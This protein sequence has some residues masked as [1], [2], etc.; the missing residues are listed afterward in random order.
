MVPRAADSETCEGGRARGPGARRFV[1]AS[2]Q[3]LF[4]E[5]RRIQP[6]GAQVD[7]SWGIR[8]GPSWGWRWG[9]EGSIGAARFGS[10]GRSRGGERVGLK[11]LGQALRYFSSSSVWAS[12]KIRALRLCGLCVI[13]EQHGPHS[14]TD[15]G[16]M[17]G[18]DAGGATHLKKADSRSRRSHASPFRGCSSNAHHSSGCTL[19]QAV[20]RLCV[21]ARQLMALALWLCFSSSSMSSALSASVNE[22]K[23]E[24]LRHRLWR[25]PLVFSGNRHKRRQAA[26]MAPSCPSG[27]NRRRVVAPI[28]TGRWRQSTLGGGA[29]RHWAVAP[30]R[31]RQ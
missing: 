24:L 17:Q 30:I 3:V 29:N 31:W 12:Q 14:D 15:R 6:S 19:A 10:V 11:Q 5:K 16:T 9:E 13:P 20:L 1:A 4:E 23:T 25:F 8:V 7:A 22:H 21:M 2:A 26:P 28:D 18:N 27:A